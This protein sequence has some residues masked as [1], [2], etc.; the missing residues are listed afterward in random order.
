M[1]VLVGGREI[2]TGRVVAKVSEV[3]YFY[4][5]VVFLQHF[6][7]HLRYLFVIN[8]LFY[9]IKKAIQQDNGT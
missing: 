8:K 2:R 6:V 7:L 9:E 4:L 1:T 5:F 3:N